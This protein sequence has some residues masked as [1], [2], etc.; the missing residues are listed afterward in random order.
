MEREA[1]M[2]GRVLF[3]QWYGLGLV[4][5]LALV[6]GLFAPLALAAPT[7]QDEAVI[8][9]GYLGEVG[10]EAAQGIQLAISQINSAGGITAPDGTSYR[11]EMVTPAPEMLSM[12]ALDEAVEDLAQQDVVAIFGP[13]DNESFDEVTTTTLVDTRLPVLTAATGNSLTTGDLEGQLFRLRAPERIYSEALATYMVQELGLTSIALVQADVES[14]EALVNFAGAMGDDLEP[15]TQV[16]IPGGA[17]LDDA[18]IDL[19]DLNPEAIVMWGPPQYAASLLR[20]LRDG[21]WTGQFAYRLADEAARGND[22]PDAVADGMLGVTSWG[23]S[24]AS[25]PSQIFLRDY[26]SAFGE[27]PGPLAVATYDGVWVLRAAIV[28]GGV[29]PEEIL[30]ALAVGAPQSLVQGTLNPSAYGNG[31]LIHKAM[32]YELGPWGGLTVLAQYIDGQPVPLDQEA[33]IVETPVAPV[34]TP[35]PEVGEGAY[36]VVTTTALN[37]RSGPGFNFDQIGEVQQGDLLEILGAVADYS[38]LVINYQGGI[39]WIKAEFA[40]VT[41]DLGS[42]P[43]LQSPATPTPAVTVPPAEGSL[44]DLLVE[45]VVLN[46]SQPIPNQPFTATVSV[47]NV[48]GGAAGRFAVGLTFDQV[49]YIS[50]YIEGLASGQSGQIQLSSTVVGTGTA[51]M[52]VTA[53]L[54]NEIAEANETNNTFAQTVQSSAATLAEQVN[55]Q[56]AAGTQFDL[57]GGTVDFTW[58]GYN[59]AMENGARMGVLGVTYEAASP[60]DITD[61]TINNSVGIGSNQVQPGT[62]LGVIT[63]E[64]ARAVARVENRQDQTVWISYKVFQ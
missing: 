7:A 23:Y 56:L 58:D 52:V 24:Y 18:V 10:D 46:P 45:S 1:K 63:A 60:N 39:G 35:N 8:R 41:G 54:N 17:G 11:L 2:R 59:I 31:D 42:I 20:Q 3:R 49:N 19:G 62:V 48:G 25:G 57:Y 44:A 32:I 14:T 38:W 12:A 26:V 27:V 6:A 43:I 53:D 22:L 37:V 28:S 64:G 13:N 9:V 55:I 33:P 36:A 47:R 51:Q 21:G 29:T 5:A 50:G 61:A 40:N 4:V 34:T 16:Q 30:A 15:A